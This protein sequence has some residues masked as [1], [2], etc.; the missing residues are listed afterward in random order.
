MDTR[1]GEYFRFVSVGFVHADPGHLL[2][3]MLTLYFFGREI[4]SHIFSETQFI[5][6]YISAIAMSC[7][8]E[9]ADQKNNPNYKACGASGGVSAVLFALVLFQPWGVV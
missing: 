3:N 1:K 6:F 5:M 9:Y 8:S 7:A 4:E 2:F